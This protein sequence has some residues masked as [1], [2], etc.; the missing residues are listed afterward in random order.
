MTDDDKKKAFGT[1]ED[2]FSDAAATLTLKIPR[3]RACGKAHWYPRRLCPFCL[4]DDVEMRPVAEGATI[5]SYT[6]MRRTAEPYAVAY[7]QLRE[8]PIMLTNIIDTDFVD[9]AIGLPVVPA[10]LESGDA[11]VP[12]FRVA[13]P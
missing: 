10:F 8:G 12:A 6:I 3:C 9:L 2:Y 1:A 5:Y 7:V 11:L 13:K 4:S